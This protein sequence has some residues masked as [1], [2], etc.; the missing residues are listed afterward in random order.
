MELEV[1]AIVG[2]LVVLGLA[3]AISPR[4]NRWQQRRRT[5][6]MIEMRCRRMGPRSE[7]DVKR[8]LHPGERC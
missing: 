3:L 2:G 1:T 5:N 6:R 8:S 7:G 4:I